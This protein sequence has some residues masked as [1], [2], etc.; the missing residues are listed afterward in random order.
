MMDLQ[1]LNGM[2][3][4]NIDMKTGE[5]LQQDTSNVVMR[6]DP[7]GVGRAAVS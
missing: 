6:A 5:Y 3:A 2:S 7:A 4:W 1:V